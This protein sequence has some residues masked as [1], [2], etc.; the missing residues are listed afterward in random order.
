MEWLRTHPFALLFAF[1]GLCLLA[2]TALTAEKSVDPNSHI[3]LVSVSGGN[4][5]QNPSLDSVS[6][7]SGEPSQ[8]ETSLQ[9]VNAPIPKESPARVIAPADT[10]STHT[11]AS[12]EATA[13]L[14]AQTPSQKSSSAPS[15]ADQLLSEVYSFVPGG[16]ALLNTP[17]T[18]TP[19][20]QALFTY[21]NQAGLVVL[22]FEN[23][24]PGMAEALKNWFEHRSDASNR[25]IVE[26]IAQDMHAAG[27]GLLALSAPSAASVANKDL[28][29]A[30]I[31]ASDEL[32]KVAAASGDDMQLATA[33]K[34]YNTSADAFIKKYIAL[35][36]VFSAN[37]VTFSANDPGSAFTFSATSGL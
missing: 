25:S 4:T 19:T 36:D 9:P 28:A 18:R 37:E 6:S 15:A 1:A 11:S 23:G 27:D 2:I 12:Y 14:A 21:G 20:Q 35:S 10:A 3:S 5:F 24:H 16:S 33:M 34:V 30:F 8:S 31:A 29:T 26:T 17:I 22:T 32:F 13:P 7:E